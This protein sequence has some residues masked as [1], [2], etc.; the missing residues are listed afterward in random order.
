MKA[1]LYCDKRSLNNATSYYISIIQRCLEKKGFIFD[2]VFSLPS[3]LKEDVIITITARYF[4]KSKIKYPCVKTIFWSQGLAAEEAKM[5][6]TNISTFLSYVFRKIIEPIAIKK[7]TIL[8]CVSDSMLKY[9]KKYYKYKEKGNCVVMPCYNLKLSNSFNI[10]Q[11]SS[12]SFVYAGNSSIW[13][14]VDIM[15]DV[16]ALIEKKIPYSK[17]VIFTSDKDVF[18]NK[19]KERGI[20]NYDIKF[21]PISH[22]QDELHKYKYGFIIRENNVVNNVA[23]PTKMNS[24]LANYMIP[25]F[26]DA[27]DDFMKNIKLGEFTLVTKCPLKTD[28]IASQ[29][30]KF[31]ESHKVYSN[32][33]K[34]VENVFRQYYDD[35]IYEQK[36]HKIIDKYLF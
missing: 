17:L 29:I 19:I 8:F 3:V 4:L 2:V 30:I 32:Y 20:I 13:Q 7:S 25:I 12:P 10:K 23:T 28:I 36:F 27:V 5:R 9:Y 34:V 35:S 18:K 26:S 1:Y 11:Y 33:K 15:L 14:G 21:V 24:Y 22:L 31:E 6:I 16:Y